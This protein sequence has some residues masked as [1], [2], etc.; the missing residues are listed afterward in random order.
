MKLA[1]RAAASSLIDHE[2]LGRRPP[3]RH[4][5]LLGH[6]HR[7]WRVGHRD[8]HGDHETQVNDEGARPAS[9]APLFALKPDI[10]EIGSCGSLRSL[11]DD[12]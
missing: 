1:T 2:G 8:D 9:R 3:H 7:G 12:R 4:D 5:G 11:Q 10:S 6:L